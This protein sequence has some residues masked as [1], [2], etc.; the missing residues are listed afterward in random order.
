MVLP[1]RPG[2]GTDEFGDCTVLF[3]GGLGWA[4]STLVSFLAILSNMI[5]LEQSIFQE[6]K[7][8]QGKL[9]LQTKTT[10]EL[11]ENFQ[12]IMCIMK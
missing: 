3:D 4:W 2:D 9:T 1:V 6:N 7:L 12:G 5:V 11:Q 8:F 10:F